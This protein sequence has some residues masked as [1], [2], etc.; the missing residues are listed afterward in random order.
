MKLKKKLSN[1]NDHFHSTIFPYFS[2]TKRPSNNCLQIMVCSCVISS[3]CGLL[4]IIFCPY[5]FETT[6]F[7]KIAESFPELQ[8][9]YLTS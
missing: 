7:A 2:V 3:K 6:F 8:E 9:C 4:Q 5:K 1:D